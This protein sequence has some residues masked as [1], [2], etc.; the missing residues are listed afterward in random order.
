MPKSL[1]R[2]LNMGTVPTVTSVIMKAA[3]RQRGKDE[4]GGAG[5]MRANSGLSE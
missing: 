4:A 1:R 3:R 5:L 2:D